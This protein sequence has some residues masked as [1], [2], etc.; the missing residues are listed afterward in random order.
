MSAQYRL[1]VGSRYRLPISARCVAELHIRH[2][3]DIGSRCRADIE[4]NIGPMSGRYRMFAGKFKLTVIRHLTLKNKHTKWHQLEVE[5]VFDESWVAWHHG[6]SPPTL[7]VHMWGSR[8][9]EWPYLYC[10]GHRY[11]CHWTTDS[12]FAKVSFLVQYITL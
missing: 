6:F 1:H 11:T 8:N 7:T 2:R 9:P 10:P 3:A 4:S 12:Y 5:I